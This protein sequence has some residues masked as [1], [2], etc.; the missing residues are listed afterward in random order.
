MKRIDSL[1]IWISVETVVLIL[2][3]VLTVLKVISADDKSDKSTYILPTETNDEVSI[4]QIEMPVN[5]YEG[6]DLEMAEATKLSKDPYTLDDYPTEALEKLAGMDTAQKTACLFV[7]TPETLCGVGRVT[8]AGD[9]FRNSYAGTSVS[10]IIVSDRNMESETAGMQ[11]L[12]TIRDLSREF[13]GMNVLLGYREQADNAAENV[14][15]RGFNLFILSQDADTETKVSEAQGVNMIP[16]M[17]YEADPDV[18]IASGAVKILNTGSVLQVIE[19]VNAGNSV[20]YSIDSKQIIEDLKKAVETGEVSGEALDHAA[21]YAVTLRLA[22]TQARPEEYEK[23]PETTAQTGT[24]NSAA[25]KTNEKPKTP[26]E[27]A[28]EAAA[29][30]AAALQKQ[31]EEAQKAATKQIEDAQTAAAAAAAQAAPQ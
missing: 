11:M 8:R 22:L 5:L 19:S 6:E 30:Q 24:D 15:D 31:L 29:A 13:T 23:V 3:A 1:K 21:G 20:L 9:V 16:G 10:G 17:F 14:S 28:A 2:V 27:L 26:E 12:K 18:G 7:T 25:P 4:D